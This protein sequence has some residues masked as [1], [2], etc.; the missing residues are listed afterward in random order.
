MKKYLID[1][2]NTDNEP[3]LIEKIMKRFTVVDP[4]GRT[5][6]TSHKTIKEVISDLQSNKR[7]LSLQTY[8]VE[9]SIDDIEINADELLQAWKEGERPEDLQMF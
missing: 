6:N 9:C 3:N 1:I 5:E 7:D 4:S 8:F 2:I